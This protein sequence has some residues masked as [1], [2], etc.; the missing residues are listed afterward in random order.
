M[1]P[2]TQMQPILLE[3]DDKSWQK[4]LDHVESWL[5]NVMLTQSSYRQLL[6]DT[7]GKIE[8]PHIK[9]YLS[10]I[11]ERAKKHEEKVEELYK[12]INRN[13]S[14]V[15]KLLGEFAGKTRQVL[16]DFI[17]LAGGAKGPW[18]DVHQL[19]LSNYNSMGTFAV[20][21][22]LGLALGIHEIVDIAFPVIAEKSTDQLLLQEYVLEMASLSI[23]YK[24]EF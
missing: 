4:Q 11:L 15:R 23:L 20:A 10:D 7:V 14:R 18:Q 1:N 24:Q 6:E 8:E 9:K 13:P 22:Q 5:D 3:I 17:A 16:G 21:E 12:V 19:Y 2:Q